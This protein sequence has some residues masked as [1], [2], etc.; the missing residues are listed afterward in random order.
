MLKSELELTLQ[1]ANHHLSNISG[2][3]DPIKADGDHTLVCTP[4]ESQ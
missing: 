4:L 1:R 2:L 3:Y